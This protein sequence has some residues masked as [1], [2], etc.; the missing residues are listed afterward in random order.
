MSSGLGDW[1]PGD[2]GAH[3][4]LLPLVHADLRFPAAA[5]LRGEWDSAPRVPPRAQCRRRAQAEFGVMSYNEG[6]APYSLGRFH[7]RWRRSSR[8]VGC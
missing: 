1:Q 2:D 8:S 7:A 6:V 4:A 3:R 5:E